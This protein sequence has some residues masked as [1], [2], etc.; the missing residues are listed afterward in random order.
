MFR[1]FLNYVVYELTFTPFQLEKYIQHGLK[2]PKMHVKD[3]IARFRYSNA[4]SIH[5]ETQRV[6]MWCSI[7]L[8]QGL[9]LYSVFWQLSETFLI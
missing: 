6:Q 4:F 7:A 9:V 2:W 8:V 5:L 3:N 1:K